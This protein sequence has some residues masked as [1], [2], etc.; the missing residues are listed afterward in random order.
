[1]CAFQLFFSVDP[2]LGRVDYRLF[3]D[4]TLMEMFVDGFDDST[5]K[6]LQDNEGMYLDV[7]KWSCVTCDDDHRVIKVDMERPDVGGSL[8]LRYVPPKVKLLR[9]G[10]PW[11]NGYLE[12]SV[13]L[14]H[15]PEGM[16]E[17]DLRNN[18]LTGEIDLK[19]LPQGMIYLYLQNN[20][21]TGEIDLAHLPDGMVRLYLESNRF[22]GEIDLTQLPGEMEELYLSNN[23]LTGE[24]DLT[25]LPEE[26]TELSLQSNQLSGSLVIKTRRT[27][28]YINAQGNNFNAVA[29]V[30]SNTRAQIML[31]K[32]GVKSVVDENGI[33]ASERFLE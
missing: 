8:E 24:I 30:H 12:G 32:S 20:R 27:R 33:C 5:N 2:S 9:I 25:L 3:S 29:V 15:L 31:R 10:L 6:M 14:A 19:Q 13:D 22:I 4:Q 17:T 21:F 28:M 26:M 23:K 11:M 1:M 18:K 16:K 7:C